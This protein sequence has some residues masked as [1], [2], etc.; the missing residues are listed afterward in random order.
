MNLL[1]GSRWKEV[2]AN[3]ALDRL[4]ALSGPAVVGSLLAIGWLAVTDDRFVPG[5]GTAT[6]E[7]PE[8]A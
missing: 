1:R 8:P 6:V 3:R 4:S 7:E 2:R 5:R